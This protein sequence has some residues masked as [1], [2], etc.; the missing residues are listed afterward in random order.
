MLL[1]FRHR[2]GYRE[3]YDG[4]QDVGELFGDDGIDRQAALRERGEQQGRSQDAEGMI[5]PHERHGDPQKSC[6]TGEAVL[7]IT[8][9]AEDEVDATQSGE[10]SRESH[11]DP[12]HS[13]HFH[14]AVLG[15]FGLKTHRSEFVAGSRAKQIPPGGRGAAEREQ[16][17]EIGSASP[18]HG[19]RAGEP[20]DHPR[21][22]GGGVQRF[23]DMQPSRH[24]PVE[25]REYD[26]IEH[27]RDDHLARA[28]ACPERAG[29]RAND[30][31]REEGGSDTEGDGE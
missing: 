13:S 6:A 21:A 1:H 18:E 29:K 27:D 31:T 23:R 20:W 25:Q 8:L 14:A 12:Q 17:R 2:R 19:E 7:V 22:N 9:V 30:A 10:C 5:A 28:K 24:E 16:E 11:R 4:G 3:D 26:E 15:R